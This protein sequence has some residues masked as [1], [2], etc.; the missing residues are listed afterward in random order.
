MDG[1]S[2]FEY[3]EDV[4][5][6]ESFE[7]SD[8]GDESFE[9]DE[10]DESFEAS[11]E[12]DEADEAY[13]EADGEADEADEA[14]LSA[15]AEL[16]SEQARRRQ[17]AFAQKL[18]TDQRREA[19]RAASTQRSITNQ[20]RAI[21]PGPGAKVASVGSLQGAGVVTAVLP[22]GRRSRMRIIPTLAPVK[23]VNRLRSVVMVN[24]RRQAI[25]TRRNA[26]AITA[27]GGTQAAAVK[28]LT[29]QQVQSDKDLSKRV[30]ET[31]NRL[32]KRITKELSG[33]SGVVGKH[34]TKMMRALKRHRQRTLW[35]NVLLAT[36]APF[37]AAYGETGNP[38]ATNNLILTGSLLGWLFGDEVIDQFSGKSSFLKGG[39][40]LWSYLAFAGN[41]ATAYFL[42]R[43]KQHER[44]VSGVTAVAAT[45]GIAKVELTKGQIASG[46][47]DD[48][49]TKRHTVMATFLDPAEGAPPTARSVQAEV[50]ADGLLTLT[51]APKP[52]KDMKVAW[53]IDTKAENQ[54][55][56]A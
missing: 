5:G 23:E 6:D 11:D 31:Y 43:N 51:I 17:S 8:E 7:A 38:F 18:A 36:S 22:N 27:L 42:L 44:F 47:A 13:G 24:E 45:T 28:R 35:N 46:S 15:S 54:V 52:A 3:D 19:Q 2:A 26:R 14:V 50:T 10:A 55:S 37:F 41:G 1:E 25:A 16:R 21:Q 4:E 56:V 12:A 34:D 29:A 30:V 48:F 33:R 39:A 32:D 49:K 40:N 53:I 20:I 9:A